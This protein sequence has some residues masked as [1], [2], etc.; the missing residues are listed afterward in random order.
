MTLRPI[1]VCSLRDRG[2]PQGRDVVVTRPGPWGNL[3][4]VREFGFR[5][6]DLYRHDL[7]R[8]RSIPSFRNR[9]A[10]L[11]GKRLL[12]A[13]PAE[14]MAC[15]AWVLADEVNR[16]TGCGVM[17][18]PDRL[19]G[20]VAMRVGA[21]RSSAADCEEC[22]HLYWPALLYWPYFTPAGRAWR[23]AKEREPLEKWENEGGALS[24]AAE[25][26]P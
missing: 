5:C 2:E 20:L 8:K 15:H 24:P 19:D 26:S 1:E 4:P 22:G 9:L 7:R 21:R 17:P 16:L 13:C 10:G 6:L 25:V 11:A 18:A 14:A 23:S 3:W 12:C